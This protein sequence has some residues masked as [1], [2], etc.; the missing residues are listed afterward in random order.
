MTLTY[1]MNQKKERN[2]ITLQ[3]NYSAY[4]TRTTQNYTILQTKLPAHTIHTN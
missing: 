1:S 4:Y 2:I 3:K